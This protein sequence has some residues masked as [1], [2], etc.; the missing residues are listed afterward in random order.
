MALKV[1]REEEESHIIDVDASMQG[2][3]VFKEPVN[4]RIKGNFEG[5][6]EAKGNLE[7]SQSAT[8]VATIKC[9]NITI[10]GNFKGSIDSER[11]IEIL[12]QAVVE[13][14]IK[15]PRLVVEDGAIF[16]G[17][18]TMVEELLTPEELAKH[19]DVDLNTI[20][21]WAN[22]GRIPG[23]KQNDNWRFDRRKID[24][25]VAAGKLE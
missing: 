22:S 9:E 14:D 5:K 15:T 7:I 25:W 24:D 2:S 20:L 19:L 1:R 16:Q 13:G 11:K 8:V 10:R 3:L 12:N 17:K 4:L 23:F 21:S 6:L 18:C